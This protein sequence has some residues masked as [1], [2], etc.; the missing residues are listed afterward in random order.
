MKRLVAV[1]L[2]AS[3]ATASRGA[4]FF[5][6]NDFAVAEDATITQQVFVVA[7]SA[8]IA[9]RFEDDLFAA[10]AQTARV[11]AAFTQ[12]AWLMAPTIE[13]RGDAAR[14][15]RVAGQTLVLGGRVG[16]C[17]MAAGATVNLATN[18]S[19]GNGVYAAAQD[20]VVA[21]AITGPVRI[22]A[23]NATISGA[24]HGDIDVVAD[25]I[26][27]MPGTHI[28]GNLTYVSNRELFLD[29]NVQLDGA[30]NRRVTT[31][32]APS[33]VSAVTGMI[34]LL[35]YQA[36]AAF[37]AGLPLC[38]LM[39]SLTGRAARASR[40]QIGRTMLIGFALFLGL[41]A[42][43]ILA[44][45]TVVGIPLALVL[46]AVFAVLLYLGK[47]PV[48]LAIG[49]AI[50]RQHGAVSRGAALGCL[51]V[52]LLVAYA[53]GAIPNLGASISLLIGIVGLG[54]LWLAM[55]RGEVRG[56]ETPPMPGDRE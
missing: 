43:A 21:G 8:S 26:V 10:V 18:F 28:R 2:L 11:A 19:A 47:I 49:A 38:L 15:L 1:A 6:T 24:I 54:A 17:L 12:D 46:G 30:L 50:L 52:G 9:G 22:A 13:Y 41:P 35:L 14:H 55:L 29:R 5:R 16:G 32:P 33:T 40:Q 4:E 45:L 27:V 51:G 3:L 34:L 23:R 20:I 44:A 36:G 31:A 56:P 37:L 53:L 48:A 7:Q 42:A 25:D 39:P